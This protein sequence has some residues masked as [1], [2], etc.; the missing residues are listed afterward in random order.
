M[1]PSSSRRSARLLLPDDRHTWHGAGTRSRIR[2]SGATGAMRAVPSPPEL[3]RD[4]CC[5]HHGTRG[6]RQGLIARSGVCNPTA[7]RCTRYVI[8]RGQCTG[9]SWGATGSPIGSA[10]EGPW[11][12][13]QSPA[14]SDPE[15]WSSLEAM[16][17]A[18]RPGRGLRQ[19]RPPAKVHAYRYS[20]VG[21]G[22]QR[23]RDLSCA[24]VFEAPTSINCRGDLA[25]QWRF[26]IVA[27]G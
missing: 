23:Y 22:C 5:G 3:L 15:G 9:W 10:K 24:Y 2:W 25:P 19:S 14:E 26:G 21:T 17:A 20:A 8:L 7:G 4:M 18:V 1:P 16:P 27:G 11:P 6:V 12:A 13:E